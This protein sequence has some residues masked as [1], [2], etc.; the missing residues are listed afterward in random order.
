M[1]Y[2]AYWM[3]A[4]VLFCCQPLCG[5]VPGESLKTVYGYVFGAPG[6]AFSFGGGNSTASFMFGAGAEGL[7]KGGLG[8]AVDGGYLYFPRGGLNYGLGMIS[9][10]GLYQFRTNRNTVPF[11]TGGYTLGFRSGVVNLIHFGGGV[12][13]WIGK[14]LGFRLEGRYLLDPTYPEANN[15]QFRAGL[16]IR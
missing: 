14:N 7:L 5:Q 2:K 10:G 12:N 16:L 4:P 6:A 11:V 15:L 9:P 8:L 13:H 1:K 3:L